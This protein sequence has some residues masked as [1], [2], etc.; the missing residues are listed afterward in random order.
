MLTFGSR[1]GSAFGF[2]LRRHDRD[3]NVST[4]IRIAAVLLEDDIKSVCMF[5]FMFV[6]FLM[7]GMW[8]SFNGSK[9]PPPIPVPLRTNPS[10][11]V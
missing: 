2:L 7:V 1:L 11:G 10:Y 4:H 8:G 9:L 6:L 5:V 3:P